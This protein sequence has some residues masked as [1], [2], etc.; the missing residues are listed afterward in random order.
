MNNQTEQSITVGID[1]GKSLLDI[2]LHPIEEYFTI[3]NDES[4][5]KEAIKRLRKKRLAR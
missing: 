4:G 2:Y 5:I 3:T 1:T